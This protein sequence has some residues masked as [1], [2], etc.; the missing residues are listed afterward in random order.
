M[1]FYE[2]LSVDKPQL[3]ALMFSI[4]SLWM[5]LIWCFLIPAGCLTVLVMVF[6]FSITPSCAPVSSLIYFKPLEGEKGGGGREDG[7]VAVKSVDIFFLHFTTSVVS[8]TKRGRTWNNDEK[9]RVKWMLTMAGWQQ[10][11]RGTAKCRRK[12][13]RSIHNDGEEGKKLRQRSR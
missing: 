12:K 8:P 4:N 1:C 11:D 10:R 3:M 9:E 2:A 6:S 5:T 13:W 7:L